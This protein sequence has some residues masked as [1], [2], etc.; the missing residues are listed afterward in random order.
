MAAGRAGGAQSRAGGCARCAQ[1][2]L[3]P[4][5]STSSGCLCDAGA[6]SNPASRNRTRPSST[7]TRACSCSRA[8]CASC[9]QLSGCQAQK[10]GMKAYIGGG[11]RGGGFAQVG[12]A[13]AHATSCT[14][15]F[16]IAK[17]SSPRCCSRLLGKAEAQL[18]LLYEPPGVMLAGRRLHC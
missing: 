1:A 6:S 7:V 11:G 9:L 18:Q 13:G 15:C 16:H 5:P 17:I 4:Q 10:R 14:A 3:A 12:V 2:Q 8:C